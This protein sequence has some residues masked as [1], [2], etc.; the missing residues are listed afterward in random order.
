MDKRYN[1]RSGRREYHIPV[2][3]QLARDEEFL[4]GSLSSPSET[5]QVFVSDNSDTSMSDIDISTLLNLD[6]NSSPQHLASG[7]DAKADGLGQQPVGTGGGVAGI[8]YH[9]MILIK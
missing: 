9:R 2:Q 1:L 3:L 7:T 5:G 4:A 8:L 6:Q